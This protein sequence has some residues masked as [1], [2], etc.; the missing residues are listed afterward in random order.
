MSED[1][2]DET[3]RETDKLIEEVKRSDLADELKARLIQAL[4]DLD[5]YFTAYQERME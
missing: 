5:Y 4:K 1:E 2:D 3:P